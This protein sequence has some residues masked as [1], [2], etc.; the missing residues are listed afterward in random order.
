MRRFIRRLFNVF[1]GGRSADDLDREVASHLALLED[2]Y[3]R[4]GLTPEQ[5][6]LT[7][8]RAV[9]SVALAKDL[10]RDA[11]SFVWLEDLRR[12]VTHAVRALVRTPAFTASVVL[13]LALG[14][15][16]NTAIFSVVNAVLLRPLP[17]PG[18]DRLVYVTEESASDAGPVRRPAMDV[19][20]LGEFRAHTRAL[21]AVGVQESVTVTLAHGSETVRLGA[22]RLSPAYLSMLGVR[23]ALGR[24]FQADA[25]QGASEGVVLLGYAAWQKYFGGAS[26]VV[27]RQVQLDGRGYSIVGV[28]PQDFLFYPNLQAEVWIP[29]VIPASGF[30]MLPVVGQLR[31]GVSIEAAL[32]ETTTILK[33]LRGT[34]ETP[35]LALVRVQDQMV[36]PVRTALLVLSVTVGFVLLISCVNVANLVLARAS[37]REREI[38]VRRALGASGGRIARWFV[39]ESLV[40]AVAGGAAGIALAFGGINVL[41]LFG[42]SLPRQDLGSGVSIPR[43]AEVSVDASTLIFALLAS[44]LTGVVFGLAPVI[45]RDRA[46]PVDALRPGATRAGASGG[47]LTRYRLRG[48]LVVAEIGMALMLLVGASLMLNSF[49]RLARVDPGYDST[50]VLTFQVTL[51]EGRDMA[52]FAEELVG[53]LRSVRGVRMAGYAAGLPMDQSRGR[54]PLRSTPGP[55]KDKT[56]EGDRAADPRYVS[57]DYLEAMGIGVVAGRRFSG[58]DVAGNP[59]VIVV[60]RSLARSGIVGRDPVGTRVYGL[61]GKPWEI[62]GVVEDVRQGGLDREPRPQFFMDFRQVPGFPFSELRPYFAVRTSGEVTPLLTNLRDIVRQV[63]SRA[64]VDNVAT[65]DQI[66]WNSISRPR[67]YTVLLSLLAT[68][69]VVLAAVGIFG[70]MAYLMEQRAREIGIRMALGARRSQVVSRVLGQSSVLVLIGVGLGLALALGLTRYLEGML[71]G[72]TPLDPATFAAAT[73]LFVVVALAASYVPARR[74]TRVDPLV[75]LRAE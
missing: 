33:E 50:G 9:G 29:Y 53:R 32:A 48:G 74:A 31:E 39:A 42:T 36:A 3:R 13:T 1:R 55:P 41:R 65:M 62:V 40:L 34:T 59:L 52:M 46:D 27:G 63:E 69:A 12:D 16:A 19:Q 67:L 30:A 5:A 44:L 8:R 21:S 49:V 51:P 45:R 68:V 38:A 11:R 23:P 6:R 20:T 66:V 28:M 71:F 22:S 72:L 17:Y 14:I 54:M 75:A 60:N 7:A 43:L 15:G 10:H 26:D 2:E 57:Q 61:F 64:S 4:R 70:L 56:S 24:T 47:H 37:S 18:A 58:G 25:G 73:A 35:A